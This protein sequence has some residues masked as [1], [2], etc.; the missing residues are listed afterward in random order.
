[1]KRKLYLHIGLH[2]TGTTAIQR[3]LIN[4]VDQLKESGILYPM[5]GIPSGKPYHRLFFNDIKGRLNNTFLWEQLYQE[6]SSNPTSSVLLSDEAWSAPW[7]SKDNICALR[8]KFKSYD[9]II[10][11]LLR[12]PTDY[13]ISRYRHAIRMSTSNSGMSFKKFILESVPKRNELIEQLNLWGEFF[14]NDHIRILIYDYAKK[15]KLLGTHFLSMLG[16]NIT[17]VS[18]EKCNITLS[19]D[20]LKALRLLMRIE[21]IIPN[22]FLETRVVKDFFDRLRNAVCGKET[23]RRLLFRR[24]LNVVDPTNI[25]PEKD[26]KRLQSLVGQWPRELMDLDWIT[27]EQSGHLSREF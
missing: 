13:F 16:V 3:W 26:K 24:L 21:N 12:N 8:D 4:N 18:L 5:A 2:K 22:L 19:D 10:L 20:I 14:G 23:S 17:S 9:V 1:M 25:I 27:S 15:D 7:I 11:I 6:I